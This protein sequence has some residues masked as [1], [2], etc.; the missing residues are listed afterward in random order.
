MR[1]LAKYYSRRSLVLCCCL[2]SSRNDTAGALTT[3]LTDAPYGSA[4]EEAKVRMFARQ[5]YSED[6]ADCCWLQTT[7]LATVLSVLNTTRSTDIAKVVQ[8]LDPTA[9]DTLMK[10][11]Y[12]GMQ[13]VEEGGNC[14]VLLNWHEKVRI[15]VL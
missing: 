14:S 10:Y 2:C 12:K 6:L 7:S 3:A 11:L 5:S 9:Q 1:Q 4:L 13:S 8:A 15:T